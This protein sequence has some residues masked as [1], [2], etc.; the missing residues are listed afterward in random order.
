LSF[1]GGARIKAPR[2]GW[3]RADNLASKLKI[4]AIR[5]EAALLSAI[6]GRFYQVARDITS[7]AG[8]RPLLVVA[9]HPDDETLGC[10]VA[11]MRTKDIGQRVKVVVVTDGQASHH[12]AQVT[13]DQLI[14]LRQDE[15]IAA[16]ERMGL[17]ADDVVFLNLPDG[18]AAAHHDRGLAA[19]DREIATFAP[20]LILYPSALDSHPDHRAAAR[21]VEQLVAEGRTPCPAYAYPIWFW[22]LRAWFNP[23]PMLSGF[24][25]VRL[26]RL[27]AEGYGERKRQALAA[28]RSQFENLT[29]EPGWEVLRPEFTQH[30]LGPYELYFEPAAKPRV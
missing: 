28:H 8:L 15:A 10:G 11:I 27:S 19:L 25:K 13:R 3:I 4:A 30:F 12:S 23:I 5:A 6:R 1:L 24:F 22:R 18:E 9:P 17:S 16:C 14:K 29:G 7:E 2:H 20:G 21:M 26:L